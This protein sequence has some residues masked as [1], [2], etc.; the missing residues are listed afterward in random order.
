MIVSKKYQEYDINQYSPL[1]D[2][3]SNWSFINF[4]ED[5]GNL[6]SIKT[7]EY[8]KHTNQLSFY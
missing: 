4:I 2:K 8:S 1:K 5:C 6:L 7:I 3:F